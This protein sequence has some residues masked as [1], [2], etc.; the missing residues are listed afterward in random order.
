MYKDLPD[1]AIKDEFILH[2]NTD[3]ET[4]EIDRF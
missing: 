3:R 2:N 4:L 1:H